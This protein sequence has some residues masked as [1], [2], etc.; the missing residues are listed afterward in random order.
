MTGLMDAKTVLITGA[1]SGI[2]AATAVLMARQ[3]ARVAVGY[4]SSV[5]NAEQVIAR[6]AGTGHIAVRAKID[7]A[8]SLAAAVETIEARFGHLDVLVN[9]GGSTVRVPPAQ[10]DDLTDE[11]FDEIC[12]INLRG[13]FA[14]IRAF[15]PLLRKARE[16]A[17]VVN[18]GSLAAHTGVGSNLAY[19]ASKAGLLALSKGL[20]RVI[21]PEIRVLSVSP[22]GVETDFIKGR[23]PAV[24]ARNAKATPLKRS[25]RPEAVAQTVLACAA[26]M[27]SAT[28]IDIVV[29]EGRHLVGWPL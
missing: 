12:H 25:T 15:V 24:A 29:D 26:L 2:G 22:G 10:I 17:V 13:P 19:A 28:G 11:I 18:I 21:G 14:A 16:G 6:M 8:D 1:G 5:E 4:H 7:A 3:G 20:A 9:S 23:D 27:P